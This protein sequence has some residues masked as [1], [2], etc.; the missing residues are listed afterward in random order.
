MEAEEPMSPISCSDSL[1][2]VLTDVPQE[3]VDRDRRRRHGSPTSPF[4]EGRLNFA[5]LANITM[6]AHAWKRQAGHNEDLEVR[7][8]FFSLPY[9]LFAR[10]H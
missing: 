7:P 2:V 3:E 8:L 4:S 9:P 10:S 6:A 1:S 5:A